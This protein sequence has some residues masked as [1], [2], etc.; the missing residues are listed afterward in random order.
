MGNIK[1]NV[2]SIIKLIENGKAINTVKIQNVISYL[3]TFDS[4]KLCTLN[5]VT[6]NL[7]MDDLNMLLTKKYEAYVLMGV[8][9][10]V[11]DGKEKTFDIP[12]RVFKHAFIK[13]DGKTINMTFYET[14]EGKNGIKN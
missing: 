4:E 9:R 5:V 14:L 7:N 13:E 1:S 11:I 6:S 8:K 3:F 2:I 12:P 10:V